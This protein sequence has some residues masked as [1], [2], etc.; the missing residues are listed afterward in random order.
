MKN[1]NEYTE[2]EQ[3]KVFNELGAFFA[4]GQKQLDEQKKEDIIYLNLGSGLICPSSK[5][6]ELIDRIEDIHKKAI[7]QRLEDYGIEKIIQYELSNY[8][9]QISMDYSDA[10]DVLQDYGVTEEQMKKQFKIYMD[11]CREHDLF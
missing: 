4:F 1:L 11:Y 10:F 2:K 3:T 8:E 7:N 6:N 9:C 5:A